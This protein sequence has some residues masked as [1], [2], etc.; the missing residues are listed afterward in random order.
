MSQARG[1]VC[2]LIDPEHSFD[3]KWFKHLGG[4]P[5]ELITAWPEVAEEAIEAMMLLFQ[6]GLEIIM[7][8]SVASLSTKEE[9]RKAP[10]A[11]KDVRIASQARFMSTNLRRLTTVNER[12]LVLWTN[13]NRT[14]IGQF[15]GDPTTQ[16]GGRALKY[17]DT[18]RIELRRGEAIKTK[19]KVASTKRKMVDKDLN[20]GYWVYA[21]AHKNKVSREGLES[22]F[23]FD[24]Q[25]GEIDEAA[26]LIQLGLSDGLIV[27]SGDT[28]TYT[29][30]DDTEWKGPYKKFK[31][32]LDD[33]PQLLVEIIEQVK[34]KTLELAMPKKTN[35][36]E[37]DDE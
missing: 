7:V 31:K 27:R 2:G 9:I 19:S 10:N 12:T 24:N 36:N 8:D 18:A 28:F 14:K 20:T 22:T 5:E 35:N 21:K 34:E 13:Q 26:E 16:P 23:V 30:Y 3:A 25:R 29:D 17:Y 4:R 37:A 32:Y 11:D 15:F 6:K 1:N 33:D